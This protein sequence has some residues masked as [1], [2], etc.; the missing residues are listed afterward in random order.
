MHNLAAKKAKEKEQREAAKRNTRSS[1]R[2][3]LY[4]EKKFYQHC[5]NRV[6]QAV[7]DEE[8]QKWESRR[9]KS[10]VRVERITKQ[11]QKRLHKHSKA[12]TLL[13]IGR[14]ILIFDTYLQD[15]E[16]QHADSKDSKDQVAESNVQESFEEED[17]HDDDDDDD[18][19][20]KGVVKRTIV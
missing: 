13:L 7:D 15:S 20:M 6:L 16:F 8:Y 5:E 14:H 1:Q 9:Y 12:S 3:R 18:K 4:K 17:V 11:W 2:Q 19:V 10:Q